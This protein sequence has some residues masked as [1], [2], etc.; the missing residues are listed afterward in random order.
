MYL[1]IGTRLIKY[2]E[3]VKIINNLKENNTFN[4]IDWLIG[5][6]ENLVLDCYF[7]ICKI[8]SIKETLVM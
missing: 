8:I 6:M 1:N 2:C 5:L 4:V 7:N 3:D